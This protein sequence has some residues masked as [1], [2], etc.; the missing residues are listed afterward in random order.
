MPDPTT[1]AAATMVDPSLAVRVAEL[2]TR[3]GQ[4][5]AVSE[6]STGGLISAALLSV[7]GASAFFLGGSITYTGKAR[8]TLLGITPS[9]VTGMRSATP[10]MAVLL[11]RTVRERLGADWGLAETGAAG[12]SGNRYGDAA[13]HCCL[14]IVGPHESARVLATRSTD[15]T[16]NMAAF[17]N[18]ALVLMEEAASRPYSGHALCSYV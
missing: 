6:S 2:L 5:L 12:P 17:A 7:P 14:A 18:A 13:G 4:T 10:E 9:M 16:A 1:P 15:R 8:E 11:A 3:R